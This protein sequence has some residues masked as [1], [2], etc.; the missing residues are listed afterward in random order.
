MLNRVT[1]QGRFT[2]DPILRYTQS[3]KRVTSFALAVQADGNNDQADFIDCVAWENRAQF[4]NEHFQKGQPAVIEGRLKTRLWTTE[5]GETRK[6]TE[7]I[8]QNI[9][10]AGYAPN[11][12][13]LPASGDFVDIEADDF[14]DNPFD[15]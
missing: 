15:P 3:Q 5:A 13:Q 4:I 2:D 8:V 12:T 9:Y 1:I 10:F 14:Q 11:P 6:A 7:V